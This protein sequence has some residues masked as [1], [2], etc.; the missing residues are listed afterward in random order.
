MYIMKKEGMAIFFYIKYLLIMSNYK[1][2]NV[3]I[4]KFNP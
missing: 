3:Q 2:K 4:F 1:E